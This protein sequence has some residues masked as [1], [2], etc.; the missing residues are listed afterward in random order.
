MA[1]KSY[2][3]LFLCTGNSAR[4]IMAEGLMNA[5]GGRRGFKA[6]SAG[7]F[8]KGAVHELAL[9]TLADARIPT[10]GFRSKSWDEFARPGAPQMDF[11]FTV[12]DQAAAEVCPVWPGQ[13]MT[14]HWGVPDPAAVVGTD[15]VKRKAFLDAFV[16]LKR[17]IELMLALPLDRLDR[18]AIQ[19]KVRDIGTQ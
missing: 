13:P 6:Y 4:S 2:N 18:L 14:A 9:Q 15:V 5:L 11:V 12:C 8:P 16:A 7:S 17:R 1:G 3:V 19:Q 10:D